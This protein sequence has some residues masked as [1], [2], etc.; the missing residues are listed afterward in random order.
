MRLQRGAC[1][2]TCSG[3]GGARRRGCTHAVTTSSR[4]ARPTLRSLRMFSIALSVCWPPMK[5]STI[6]LGGEPPGVACSTEHGV[7]YAW[8]AIGCEQAWRDVLSEPPCWGR[9]AGAASKGCACTCA[10][11]EGGR[12]GGGRA[13]PLLPC[14]PSA[15]AKRSATDC[16]CCRSCN[17]PVAPPVLRAE[18][19]RGCCC[20][21]W[22]VGDG[23][24][25]ARFTWRPACAEP[26]HAPPE[27]PLPSSLWPAPACWHHFWLDPRLAAE[28]GRGGCGGCKEAPPSG[29]ELPPRAG[30]R[31]LQAAALAPL[32][33]RAAAELPGCSDCAALCCPAAGCAPA[34]DGCAALEPEAALELRSSSSRPAASCVPTWGGAGA[35]APTATEA[36]AEAGE[37]TLSAAAA[38]ADIICSGGAEL[39]CAPAPA[40]ALPLTAAG[41]TLSLRRA[42][43]AAAGRGKGS[44]SCPATRAGEDWPPLLPSRLKCSLLLLRRP[45]AAGPCELPLLRPRPKLAPVGSNM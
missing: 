17:E 10:V 42:V 12:D 36:G 29:S 2:C 9:W 41:S 1:S 11:P 18:L 8:A 37:G 43:P 13:L 5:L 19:G 22:E 28:G 4:S 32:A 15:P 38:A 3:S 25:R 26:W 6:T 30:C 35:T 27:P 7:R 21:C 23:E 31:P 45:P 44:G 33:R 24:G 40:A 14:S 20:C 16:S 39:A 34:A